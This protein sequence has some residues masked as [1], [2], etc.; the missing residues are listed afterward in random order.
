MNS[1][2][3]P[4]K[5]ITEAADWLIRRQESPLTKQEQEQFDSWHDQSKDHQKAWRMAQ[6]LSRSFQSV[7]SGLG[8]TVLKRSQKDRRQLIKLLSGL[9]VV[10]VT[11]VIAFKT[12][13]VSN[14]TADL[15]TATGKQ[16]TQILADGSR[17]IMNTH[18]ALN[19]LFDDHLRQIYLIE[20]QIQISTAKDS[21][22][23]PFIVT[24]QYGQVEALGTVFQLNQLSDGIEV[25]VQQDT[26]EV[27]T[28]SG[29]KQLLQAGQKAVFSQYDISHPKPSHTADSAWVEGQLI[30]DDE[31]LSHVIH[32][33]SR[34]R[35][36][37]LRCSPDVANLKVSGVFQLH[38]T[39]TVLKNLANTL[40]ISLVYRTPYWVTVDKPN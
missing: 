32:E 20:G 27:T 34:Y 17:I 12:L 16:K 8:N 21:L 40:P 22:S 10:P 24:T 38:D 36:G 3:P 4:N 11:G 35:H 15:S 7:P 14:W 5:I 9:L 6:T 33:I 13:P 2:C 18:T 37:W 30:V 1:D 31:K 25:S 26:V 28:L 23:R 29:E 39:D 19:I